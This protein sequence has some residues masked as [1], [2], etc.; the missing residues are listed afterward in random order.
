MAYNDEQNE[1]PLP[2][3]DS[4]NPSSANFLPRYFR[5]EATKSF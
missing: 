5:T 3:G 2:A 4:K 1:Y